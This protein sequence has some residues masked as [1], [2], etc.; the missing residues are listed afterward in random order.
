MTGVP[1]G[2]MQIDIRNESAGD[3][4]A[5]TAL[6]VAAFSAAPH[7]SHTEQFIV[8]ALRRSRQLAVSLV[9][10]ADEALVGHVAVSPVSITDGTCDWFGL[11]PV[12]VA[13][14]YQRRG[15]GTRLVYEALDLLRERGAGGC[16]VLGEPGYYGRF[17][18]RSSPDLVLPD[19]P[20]EYFQAL[21]FGAS[22]PRGVVAYHLAFSAR[23]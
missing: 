7:S 21:P 17:G 3:L 22:R 6:I 1:T 8:D 23:S 16:V 19:V 12:A 14:G 10:A 20:A 4:P 18:F 9:A 13:P 15:I 11:G 2:S 5:I